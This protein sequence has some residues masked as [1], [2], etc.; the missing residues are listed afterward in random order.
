MRQQNRNRAHRELAARL[1]DIAYLAIE[2]AAARR[3][4]PAEEMTGDVRTRVA[5]SMV[6]F[7]QRSKRAETS[8]EVRLEALTRRVQRWRG[9]YGQR[10]DP[11][12]QQ[13]A[14]T[15]LKALDA[16]AAAPAEDAPLRRRPRR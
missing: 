11:A 15:V 6:S 13:L 2:R 12:F 9:Y 8:D 7:W 1:F 4:G 3:C 14:R 10:L 5:L 16:A